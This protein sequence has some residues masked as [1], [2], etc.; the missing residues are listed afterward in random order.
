MLDVEV[1]GDDEHEAIQAVEAC[2][3]GHDDAR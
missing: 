1:S 3:A 2:F